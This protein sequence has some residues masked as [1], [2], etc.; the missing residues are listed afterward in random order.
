MKP[1]LHILLKLGG[2]YGLGELAVAS[3]PLPSSQRSAF[4]ALQRSPP[5]ASGRKT[6]LW[7]NIGAFSPL[8]K[9]QQGRRTSWLSGKLRQR[10]VEPVVFVNGLWLAHHCPPSK[11]HYHSSYKGHHCPTRKGS[12]TIL[13]LTTVQL[14]DLGHQANSLSIDGFNLATVPTVT[15]LPCSRMGIG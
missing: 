15:F 4:F 10:W 13:K 12:C 5:S 11:G 6:S 1:P 7:G 3:S 2:S 14:R 9:A 8:A